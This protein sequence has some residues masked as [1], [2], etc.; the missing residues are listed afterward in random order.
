MSVIE[1]KDY[2]GDTVSINYS[3]QRYINTNNCT[4]NK[5]PVLYRKKE[6]CSGCTACYTICPKSTNNC[7]KNIILQ[8]IGEISLT[9]AITM[10]A[11]SIGYLY[12]VIDISEC[13]GCYKCVSVCPFKK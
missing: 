5:A 1:F 3:S 8:E 2:N 6:E 7:V 12:P 10:I 11:D 9:G 4:Q 13:I